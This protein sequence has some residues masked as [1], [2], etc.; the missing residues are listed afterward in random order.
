VAPCARGVVVLVACGAL[1]VVTPRLRLAREGGDGGR[2]RRPM[3]GCRGSGRLRRP[4][5]GCGRGL[6]CGSIGTASQVPGSIHGGAMHFAF[7]LSSLVLL[8]TQLFSPFPELKA[9]SYS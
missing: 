6:A 4:M 3:D 7:I 5:G 8:I 2:L 9:G 1:A